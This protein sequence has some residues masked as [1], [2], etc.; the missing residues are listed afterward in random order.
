MVVEVVVTVQ[1]VEMVVTSAGC[2]ISSI[3]SMVMRG[4]DGNVGNAGIEGLL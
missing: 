2:G 1:A 3:G 4:S